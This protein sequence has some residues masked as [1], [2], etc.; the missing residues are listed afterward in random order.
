MKQVVD[1][2]TVGLKLWQY[3]VTAKV[4]FIY[5]VSTNVRLFGFVKRTARYMYIKVMKNVQFY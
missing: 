5:Y 2:K 1:P 3:D 4:S